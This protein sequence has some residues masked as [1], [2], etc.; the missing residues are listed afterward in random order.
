MKGILFLVVLLAATSVAAYWGSPYYTVWRLEQAAK[1]LDAATIARDVDLAAVKANL[2]P[3]LAERLTVAIDVEKS[4]P[5]SIL[6]RIGMAIAPFLQLK[7]ADAVLTPEGVAV[8]LKTAAPPRYTA[9]FPQA[10]EPDRAHPGEPYTLS[11]GYIKG[12]LDQFHAAIGNRLKPGAEVRLKLLRRG[13]F[14]WKVTELDLDQNA[15]ITGGSG[16][17]DRETTTRASS[18]AN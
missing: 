1:G 13:F 7:P 9:P 4:R 16:A 11:Q 10:R 3:A 12:D 8:M 17:A 2:S 18:A 6:D 15:P 5:H 14:I